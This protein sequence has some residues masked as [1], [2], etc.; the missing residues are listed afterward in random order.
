MYA[1]IEHE[2]IQLIKSDSKE[3]YNV[4]K[5]FYLKMLFFWNFYEM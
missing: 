5:D 2:C 1:F 3:V 4:T